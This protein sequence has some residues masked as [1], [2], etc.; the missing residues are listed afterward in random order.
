MLSTM[1]DL[2]DSDE[3]ALFEERAEYL[4]DS[5]FD[6]WTAPSPHE[7][8]VLR[9]LTST[10]PKLLSGPRGC[11]KTTLMKRAQRNMRIA[12]RSLPIYVNYGRSMFIEPAFTRRA[13]ADGFF[14]DWLVAKVIVGLVSE[15]D[16]QGLTDVASEYAD[17][18][19]EFVN[20]AESDPSIQRVKLPGPNRLAAH[21]DELALEAGF[22]QTV[23][24]LDDA[25]HAFVPEQQRIFFEFVR[26]LKTQRV[27]YK[28]AIYPGVTEFSPNFHVGHDAKMIR[29]W[30][31]VEGHEYLEF[32]RSAYER[33][34]PDAQRSTV[35]NEVVDFFAGASFGIPRTFFSMLEMYLDQRTE[36]SGKKPRL[37]LQVVETHADQLRAVHRGLKSK[38]PRYER[39]VEAGETVLGNGLRAIKDLN[40]GRR[41]GAPTALDLA[42]ETPSSSQLGT[43]IGLLEYVGLVRS[44]AENVSVGEHTYSKYAIHGALLVSAAALKFGQN[45]TLADR[46]RALVRSARTGSFARV[47]ESKL[48]PPAEA[49]QCQLQVGRCP[50]CGAERLHESARFCHSCGSELV[51]VSRLTELLAASIEELPLT[52][53]KLAALRDVDILTVEAIVRDRGLIEISKASRVGPT[54]ARRIYSVAEEYVGV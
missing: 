1:V 50:Q 21:L 27:T 44:T 10:G 32:M 9:Q 33:R 12:G 8:Q 15:L 48:L 47:V 53:N 45:P 4:T 46:G 49:S 52:E 23:L 35:P 43:V 26:N 54:W 19:R 16:E 30:I 40:E 38:L 22:S 36:S 14:L 11:G 51:E 41:D 31:P 28:A 24:L 7:A 17:E 13:D 3:L 20:A 25:A 34:L 37:P 6:A 29:A 18:A 5:Q 39:Y 2:H 42:I